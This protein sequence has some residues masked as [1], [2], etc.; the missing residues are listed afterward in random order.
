LTQ[1]FDPAAE[2]VYCATVSDCASTREKVESLEAG[3]RSDLPKTSEMAEEQ[4][5]TNVASWH[6]ERRKN[7]RHSKADIEYR[8][9]LKER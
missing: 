9:K 2:K 1:N 5:I 8:V 4:G 3:I 6:K 7:K